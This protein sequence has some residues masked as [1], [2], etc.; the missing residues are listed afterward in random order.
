MN[1]RNIDRHEEL[2]DKFFKIG[3]ALHEEGIDK[4]DSII[5]SMGD[6]MVLISGIIHNPDDVSLF[7]ELCGMFSAKKVLES[8][9]D[10]DLITPKSEEDMNMLLQKLRDEIEEKEN[11]KGLHLREDED[12][13]TYL[14]RM[15][16]IDRDDKGEDS[17]SESDVD[18]EK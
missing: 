4:N 13:D 6:F 12:V 14:R 8:K 5:S 18:E 15:D 11:N 10:L 7:G 16:D 17:E 9:M 3:F 2:S 1:K